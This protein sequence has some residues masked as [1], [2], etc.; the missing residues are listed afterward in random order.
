MTEINT[1]SQ[2]NAIEIDS[3]YEFNTFTSIYLSKLII[4][5]NS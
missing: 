2:L 3:L 4:Y 5:I 1:L